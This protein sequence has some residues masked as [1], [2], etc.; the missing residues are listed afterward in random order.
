MNCRCDAAMA[1]APITI[2]G[3]I[4]NVFQYN[5]RINQQCTL[6]FLIFFL[7]FNMFR[8]YSTTNKQLITEFY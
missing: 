3:H 5:K 6:Y 8:F 4:Y 2:F 1:V 7:Q